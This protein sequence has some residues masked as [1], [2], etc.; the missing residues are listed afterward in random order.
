M[1]WDWR[2]RTGVVSAAR[3]ILHNQFRY[4]VLGRKDLRPMYVVWHV[5]LRCNLA[6]SFCD[7]GAGKKYPEVRY[8]ELSTGEACRLLKLIRSACR[9][10][11]FTGGEP[12]VR[13]DLPSLL[14]YSRQ[15][16][17]WPIFVNT[18]LT[19]RKPLEEAVENIDVL[20]VSLGSAEESRYDLVIG[21]RG[22]TRKIVENL[23]FCAARQAQGGMRVVVQCVICAGRVAD[24]RTVLALC[25]QHGIWFSPAPEVRGTEVDPRLLADPGYD[26]LVDDIL[27]AKKAGARIY[28]SFQGLETLLRVRPFTCHPTLAPQLYPNGDLFYPCKPLRRI[29]ANVLETGCFEE[30][31]RAGE[32]PAQTPACDHRCHLTCYVNDSQWMENPIGIIGENIRLRHEQ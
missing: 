16:R 3:T 1:Q 15:L 26:R 21:K 24:A 20:V 32:Q 30:A 9:S 14:E 31:W 4:R 10:I 7:D 8:P 23:K 5:T 29:A 17:F 12:L 18:N 22:Q 13:K 27:A 25:R 19:L 11:Y 2:K 28:G 6:C